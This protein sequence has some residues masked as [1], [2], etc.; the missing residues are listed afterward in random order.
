MPRFVHFEIPAND[1]DKVA[2]F[3]RTIFDW[4]IAKWDGPVDY[5]PVTTG[6]KGTPGIDGALYKPTDGMSGT[7]NTVEVDNID[8]YLEKITQAGGSV[9]T[10]KHAIPT[11]GYVAYAADVEGNVFGLWQSD[12]NAGQN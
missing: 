12:P 8:T 6:D 7:I 4:E 2:A 9:T 11:V 5:W 10:P 3:Y 1:P